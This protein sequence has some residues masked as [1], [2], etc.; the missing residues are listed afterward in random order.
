MEKVDVTHA[1]LTKNGYTE[2][3]FGYVSIQETRKNVRH[4]YSISYK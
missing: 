3:S 4:Y 1:A 2:S